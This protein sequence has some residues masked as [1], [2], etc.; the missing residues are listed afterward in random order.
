MSSKRL[1]NDSALKRKVIVYAEKHGNRT[2]GRTFGISEAN[3]RRWRNDQ[4][5]IFTCKATTK[6]FMG[7][8]RG[9]Y[10]HVDE[11]VLRF[12]SDMRVKGLPVTRQA[13]RLKAGEIAKTLGIDETEFKA[14]RSW[15]DRFMRRAGLSLRRQT[16]FCSKLSADVKQTDTAKHAFREHCVPSALDATKGATLWRKAGLRGCAWSGDSEELGSDYAVIVIT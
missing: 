7:P 4:T 16:S 8:K 2:A 9:R 5:S 12:V 3:I 11:A 14:T 1:H 13:M 10:P 15:C 6:C